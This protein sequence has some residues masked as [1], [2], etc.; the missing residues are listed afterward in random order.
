MNLVL[1]PHCGKKQIQGVTLTPDV[2]VVLPCSGCQELSALYRGRVIAL[3]REVLE[4]GSKEERKEHLA[5]VI[6]E[7]LDAGLSF[8]EEPPEVLQELSCSEDF[9]PPISEEE[10][11]KFVR[12]DLKCIDSADYFKRHFN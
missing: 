3:N 1:C 10:F 2:V 6:A 7:F 9:L 5:E 11:S 8:L 4:G 12:I